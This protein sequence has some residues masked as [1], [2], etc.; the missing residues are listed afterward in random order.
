L[1]PFNKYVAPVLS[2]VGGPVGKGISSGVSG[3]SGVLDKLT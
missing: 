3:A 1:K 2:S